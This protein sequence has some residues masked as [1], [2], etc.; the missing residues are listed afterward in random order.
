MKRRD[1]LKILGLG[2]ASVVMG[3]D[4]VTI[5]DLVNITVDETVN[6]SWTLTTWIKNPNV[7][8]NIRGFDRPL[9]NSELDILYNEHAGSDTSIIAKDN[10]WHH[11]A[12]V[13]EGNEITVYVDDVLVSEEKALQ[14]KDEI[15][16]IFK[17]CNLDFGT[18]VRENI[19][20]LNVKLSDGVNLID[21]FNLS[22]N[23]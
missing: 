23:T 19:P 12:I 9:T 1:F 4:L 7:I 2:A 16:N 17:Q 10:E 22:Y 11:Y 13:S 20:E 8:N 5:D 3:K 21:G 14:A 18:W 6:K 15:F